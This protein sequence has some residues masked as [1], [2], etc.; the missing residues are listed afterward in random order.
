MAYIIEEEAL[1]SLYESMPEEHKFF[2]RTLAFFYLLFEVEGAWPRHNYQDDVLNAKFGNSEDIIKDIKATKASKKF[3]QNPKL[4]LLN[5]D[6]FDWLYFKIT[7]ED[8]LFFWEAMPSTKRYNQNV[9]KAMADVTQDIEHISNTTNLGGLFKTTKWLKKTRALSDEQVHPVLKNILLTSEA[10]ELTINAIKKKIDLSAAVIIPLTEYKE[11]SKDFIFL[12]NFPVAYNQFLTGLPPKTLRDSPDYYHVAAQALHHLQCGRIEEATA[13][14]EKSYK[15]KSPNNLPKSDHTLTIYYYFYIF[16]LTLHD[17]KN[18]LRL[19]T[20]LSAHR[21]YAIFDNFVSVLSFLSAKTT[22]P[23]K[24]HFGANADLEIFY[25]DLIFQVW[26]NPNDKVN[27]DVLQQVYQ[28]AKANGYH[29]LVYEII[30]VLL[31]NGDSGLPNLGKEAKQLEKEYGFV[32]II[33]GFK[34][35][36]DWELKLEAM[37]YVLNVADTTGNVKAPETVYC[38]RIN[39]KN[40][41]ASTFV[42]KKV[43]KNGGYGRGKEYSAGLFYKRVFADLPESD[44]LIKKSI[45]MSV[46][47][48]GWYDTEIFDYD[49]RVFAEQLCNHPNLELDS[50][51]KVEVLERKPTILIDKTSSGYEVTFNVQPPGDDR[52]IVERE[53]DTRYHA[54]VFT[55]TQAMAVN[56]FGKKLVIPKEG[57][58]AIKQL[59]GSLSTI[60]DVHSVLTDTQNLPQIEADSTPVIQLVPTREGFRVAIYVKPFVE[61]PPYLKAGKGIKNVVADYKEVKTMAI[62]NLKQETAML[63]EVLGIAT[64]LNEDLSI[65][66]NWEWELPDIEY[67]LSLLSEIDEAR[68]ANKVF[69]EWPKG[70]NIKF[71]RRLDVNSLNI[72]IKKKNDWFNVDGQVEIN[73]GLVIT[74]QTLMQ[75]S[76]ENQQF[77]QLDDGSYLT[78]TKQLRKQISELQAITMDTGKELRIHKFAIPILNANEKNLGK[79]S[80]DAAYKEQVKVINNIRNQKPELPSTFQAELRSYQ[81][82]G[83][84]WLYQLSEMGVGACLADDMGLGK[85]IQALAVA[86]HRAPQGPT[87]VVAPTS[88]CFNWINEARKFAPTLNVQLFGKGDRQEQLKN[89][90]PMDLLVCSYGLLYSQSELLQSVHFT[91]AILD[92][93]Q[94]IKNVTSKRTRAAWDLDA[95]FKL[96]TTG[97]PIENHLGELWSIFNFVNPG[98]LGTLEQFNRKFAFPIEAEQNAAA[99]NQLRKLIN[100]FVLRRRKNEVLQ[101]LPSRTEITLTVQLSQEERAYYEALR[102]SVLEKMNTLENQLNEGQK[103]LQILSELT[104]LRRF[105]CNP[106]LVD[107]NTT[108]TSSKLR[109]FNETLDE[110]LD[111]NH[112]VLVFSQF[113]AHLKILEQELINKNIPYQYLDGQTPQEQR[114]QIVKD[115]QSGKGDVFLISLKAGGVGLNLTAA[116]YVIHM[117]PWWNPAVED[118]ASD[119]AHRIGQKRPVTIYRLI[120]EE[121]IEEKI[122]GLHNTKRDLADQLLEGSESSSKLSSEDLLN[123]LRDNV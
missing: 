63:N 88:V 2:Y 118:Q 71:L 99:K 82:E 109:L 111:N 3:L 117:D 116:D 123:L 25:L 40:F 28:D 6:A 68:Q 76:K 112:K 32:S 57:E 50:G 95:D 93:A 41:F 21:K 98:L 46:N 62:R 13:L 96:A 101:E 51:V 55:D 120:T 59:I 19:I 42:E 30:Q 70:G 80:A 110:I 35:K 84:E 31:H 100:F 22:T 60:F 9:N 65:A 83:F 18:A 104:K 7:K 23:L 73:E 33:K 27:L 8:A 94:A 15:L 119:R 52:A 36:S 79:F 122:I 44:Y 29:F 39:P 77:I 49:K 16:S 86:L 45:K 37:K 66:E 61:N 103:K 12:V 87:L 81:R 114:E 1:V 67:C 90:G 64:T 47:R 14:F 85:T 107:D 113:I 115:F 92:E 121:T 108:I 56:T 5:R 38:W 75:L 97:T 58:E 26:Q 106:K 17:I 43:L 91:T 10:K 53:T 11:A 72:R 48:S 74:L 89:L 20:E 54:T 34:P 105:C 102:R 78:L 4:L 69:L 24:V